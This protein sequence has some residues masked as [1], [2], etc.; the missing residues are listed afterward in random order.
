MCAGKGNPF[1]AVLQGMSGQCSVQCWGTGQNCA[2]GRCSSKESKEQVFCYHGRARC[3]SSPVLEKNRERVWVCSAS[4]SLLCHSWHPKWLVTTR[5]ASEGGVKLNKV[6]SAEVQHQ[7]HVAI[8]MPHVG[9]NEVEQE[10]ASRVISIIR[11]SVECSS[12]V[13]KVAS[14]SSSHFCGRGAQ[15]G[16]W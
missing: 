12:M 13:D 6:C 11:G 10:G 9:H 16:R 15:K 5:C 1:Y 7:L 4:S 2:L 3:E 14:Y 8:A